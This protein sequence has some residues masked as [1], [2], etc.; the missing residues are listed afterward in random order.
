MEHRVH[1]SYSPYFFFLRKKGILYG[2]NYVYALSQANHSSLSRPSIIYFLFSPM[3]PFFYIFEVR[4][5]YISHFELERSVKLSDNGT[6][7]FTVIS[8]TVLNRLAWLSPIKYCTW[9]SLIPFTK[10]FR[11]DVTLNFGNLLLSRT[12]TIN[13]RFL[14]E[15][16]EHLTWEIAKHR[17]CRNQQISS[18]NVK[19]S[20]LLFSWFGLLRFRLVFV[21][22]LHFHLICFCCFL[23]RQKRWWRR[24]NSLSQEIKLYVIC[25][26][27]WLTK[28]T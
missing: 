11:S 17:F 13:C 1:I 27:T 23:H 22:L 12:L 24:V 26:E 3:L 18:D 6:S 28:R 4:L 14:S 10:S 9:Q 7:V 5:F 21:C 20:L 25:T 15:L 2:H 19:T 8:I 16:F